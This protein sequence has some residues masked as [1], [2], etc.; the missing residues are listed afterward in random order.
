MGCGVDERGGGAGGE[1]RDGHGLFEGGEL[2]GAGDA[3]EPVEGEEEGVGE[4][5][6]RVEEVDV[7]KGDCAEGAR[8]EDPAVE[9]DEGE[10]D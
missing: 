7:G 8:A 9:V 1:G 10:E 2:G 5:D 6:E 3:E 4:V